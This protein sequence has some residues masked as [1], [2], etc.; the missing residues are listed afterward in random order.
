MKIKGGKMKKLWLLFVIFGGSSLLAKKAPKAPEVKESRSSGF[1]N[2]FKPKNVKKE[3]LEGKTKELRE[4][5]EA[6]AAQGRAYFGLNAP[7]TGRQSS[8][9]PSPSLPPLPQRSERKPGEK[10]PSVREYEAYQLGE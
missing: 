9:S 6:R 4:K 3:Y 7:Y 2:P 5:A 8:P 10:D 1:R